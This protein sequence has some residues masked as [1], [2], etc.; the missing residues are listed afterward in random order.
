[1][2]LSAFL[3]EHIV[4]VNVVLYYLQRCFRMTPITLIHIH[5]NCGDQTVTIVSQ[6]TQK[7][8]QPCLFNISMS[9][10]LPID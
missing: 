8:K 3:K 1:M 10:N 7:T 2:I 4:Y 6:L 5:V 9:H